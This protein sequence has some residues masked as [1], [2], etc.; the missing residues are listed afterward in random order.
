MEEEGGG[1]GRGEGRVRF[2]P[3]FGPISIL[4]ARSWEKIEGEKGEEPLPRGSRLR[5]EEEREE[6]LVVGVIGEARH[7]DAGH[8]LL[9]LLSLSA[10]AHLVS[11]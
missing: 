3:S 7:E 11:G 9:A 10:R 1:G 8:A 5:V 6:N 2:L 4:R